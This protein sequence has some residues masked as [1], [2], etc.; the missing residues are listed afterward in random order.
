VSRPA[1]GRIPLIAL[2]YAA[3]AGIGWIALGG[4]HGA[5]ANF[6]AYRFAANLLGGRG[7]VYW[8]PG[9]AVSTYPLI[10]SLL[11][12]LGL[13]GAPFTIL[14]GLISVAATVVGAIFLARLVGGRW[15][16]GIAYILATLAWPSPITL[17]ML[18]LALAGLDAARCGKWTR[19]GVLFGLAILAEPSASVPAMLTL[20]L[21]LIAGGPVWRFLLPATVIPVS[22]LLLISLSLGGSASFVLIPPGSVAFALPVI[23]TLALAR[24][25]P[26][27]RELPHLAVLAAWSAVTAL[28]ALITGSLPSAAFLL[29]PLALAS[30][31]TPQPLLVLA[32]ASDLIL[33]VLLSGSFAADP[34]AEAAGKWIAANS[35]P[36]ETV[37]T[38]DI[39]ILAFYAARPVID[40]SGKIQPVPVPFDSTFFLRFAPDMVVLK[41]GVVAP[42]QW[43]KTTY[44]RVYTAGDRLVY[45]RVVNFTPLDDHGVDVNFS[46]KLGRDDLRLHNVAIGDTLHPGDLVRVRLDWELAYQPSFDIEIKL[47]LLNEEG[48]PI[49]GMP[50][51]KLPSEQWHVGKMSTYHLITL[52]GDAPAGKLRVYLGVGIRAG[53]LGELQV[54]EVNVAR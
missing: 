46:A 45:H 43:F 39:G 13:S 30:L 8:T 23:G 1:S 14:G 16:V 27:L 3:L 25:L 37:A 40:L 6:V 31:W 11:A 50:L 41:E 26:V 2:L 20:A 42:W 51:D 4:S 54:A 38:G 44:A 47:T 19:S 29:G 24:R 53:V 10:P 12:L 21:V 34:S 17:T 5:D 18:A 36:Q 7:L 9:P 15:L 52:P 33:A 28:E 35:S 32:A 48:V 22:V 49:A